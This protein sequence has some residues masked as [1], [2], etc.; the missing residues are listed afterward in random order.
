MT[1]DLSRRCVL[2]AAIAAAAA[3]AAPP[4]HAAYPER[5]L[6]WLV[7]FAA[8]GGT[9]VVARLVASAMSTTLGQQIVVENRPGAA[10]NLAADALAKSAPD[11]YTVMTADNGTLV[12]NRALFSKLPYDPDRDLRP[13]GLLARFHLVFTVTKASP[14]KSLKEFLASKATVAGGANVG[15][16]GVGSPHHLA[17]VRLG[18]D[19]KVAFTHVAYRGAAPLTTDL[20]S[21]ATEAGIVDFAAGGELMRSGDIKPLAVFSSRRLAALPDVPT[22]EE[23]L[24]LPK[25]EAYAWQGLIINAQTSDAIVGVVEKAL[26]NAMASQAIQKRMGELGLEPLI[27]GPNELAALIESERKIWVP[28]IKELGLTVN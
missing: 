20:M 6:R 21:A 16:P 19:A 4:A 14:A 17:M 22:I 10:T 25:F 18:R 2:T 9:D 27:G 23:A 26:A 28:L 7:P 8:G 13:V 24:G 12:N 15:S 3:L 11:G 5:P 1:I